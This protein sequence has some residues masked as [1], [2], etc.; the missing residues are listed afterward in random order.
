MTDYLGI[1]PSEILAIIVSY[2]DYID[3]RHIDFHI[4]WTLCYSSRYSVYK[5]LNSKLE[6]LRAIADEDTF[7]I[8]DRYPYG[9]ITSKNWRTSQYLTIN[10]CNPQT[11]LLSEELKL[12]S[13]SIIQIPRDILNLRNLTI[14]SLSYNGIRRVPWYLVYLTKLTSL[15]LDYNHLSETPIVLAGM[16]SLTHLNLSFNHELR[17]ISNEVKAAFK[18]LKYFFLT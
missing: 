9:I 5:L 15:E 4:E 12:W 11:L 16:P 10:E 2:F 7:E 14:L 13:C 17:C 3:A 8:R 1:F 6:Y 18:H